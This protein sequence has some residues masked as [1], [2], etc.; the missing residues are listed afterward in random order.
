M[1]TAE[2]ICYNLHAQALILPIYIILHGLMMLIKHILLL[3]TLTLVHNWNNMHVDRY[4]ISA[5]LP[6]HDLHALT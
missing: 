5:T 4:E 2:N 1:I 3:A 6:L